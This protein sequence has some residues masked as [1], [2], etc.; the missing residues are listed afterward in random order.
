MIDKNKHTSTI[1]LLM[2]RLTLLIIKIE[3]HWILN[4]PDILLTFLIAISLLV[5]TYLKGPEKKLFIEASAY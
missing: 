3:L 5:S 4:W 2:T 1:G